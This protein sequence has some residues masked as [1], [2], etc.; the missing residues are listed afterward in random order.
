MRV[1]VRTSSRALRLAWHWQRP[2][3]IALSATALVV[4]L[5]WLWL[6]PQERAALAAAQEEAARLEA[7]LHSPPVQRSQQELE[8]DALNSVLAQLPPP[9]A[10]SAVLAELSSA[11]T[12]YGLQ[13]GEV[14]SQPVAT[15][16]RLPWVQHE[17]AVPVSGS[18]ADARRLLSALL[19]AHPTLALDS[20]EV[21]RA[22]P[23]SP[24]VETQLRFSLFHLR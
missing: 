11:R 12:K 20:I 6:I 7:E 2:Q 24:G 14:V 5:L 16:P 3:F 4:S 23:G 9:A 15:D 18:F 10:V 8:T 21:R 19:A 1:L 13:I 22:D 17:F